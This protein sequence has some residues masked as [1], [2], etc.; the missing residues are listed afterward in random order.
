VLVTG[1]AKGIGQ[2]MVARLGEGGARVLTTAG[3]RPGDLA[4]TS[5]FVTTDITTAARSWQASFASDSAALT[6]LS[7]SSAARQRL[8][9][10]S[11][12]STMTSGIAHST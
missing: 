10:V 5:L 2:A 12:C 4:D 6:L 3:T 8:R 7:M 11:R 1:G 9:V